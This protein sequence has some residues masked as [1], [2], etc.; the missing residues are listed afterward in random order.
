M[1]PWFWSWI[2]LVVVFV[3]G[4]AF[5]GELLILPWA[6]GAFAAAVLDV[7]RFDVGWQWLAFI[8]VSSVLTILFRRFFFQGPDS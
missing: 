5:G 4:E 7:L 8:L 6:F 2:I 3:L 1:D